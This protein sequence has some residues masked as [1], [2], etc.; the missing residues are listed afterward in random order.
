MNGNRTRNQHITP[1]M[2]LS[3]YRQGYFPMANQR[4]EIGFYFYEPRGIVPLDERFTVRRSLR[5]AIKKADYRTTFDSAPLEVLRACSRNGEVP[6]NELWLS[7][8]MIGLYMRLFEMGC[9]HSVEVWKEKQDRASE[10]IGGLYGLSFGA[11]FCGESMFS[12]APYASQIALVNLVERLRDR[13]F[14]LLDA[15]MPS[16]HLKQFGLIECSQAEYLEQF[17][18]AAKIHLAF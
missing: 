18:S 2:I 17:N 1:E 7:D 10:L 15:Q 9:M 12:R 16:D 6:V 5:N 4:C 11:A 13:G 3:A 14:R 8:E